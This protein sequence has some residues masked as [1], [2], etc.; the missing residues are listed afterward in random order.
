MK[1]SPKRVNFISIQQS[2]GTFAEGYRPTPLRTGYEQIVAHR[3]D[4]LFAT[5]AKQ[6]G[7][8]EKVT[9]KSITL[10]MADGSRKTVELGRRFGVAAG[11]IMPHEVVSPLK[12]GDKVKSGDIIAYN[13]HYFELDALNNKQA[14]W[15]AG[16]LVKTAI[17]ESTDTLEDS[18]V[19]SERISKELQ[20]KITTIREIVVKS[21]Q[22]VRNLMIE[23]TPVEAESILC[24]IEDAVTANNPLLDDESLDTLR[25]IAANAPRA[26]EKGV[27]EKIEVFYHAELDEL[28]PTLQ[29]IAVAS[30]KQRKRLARELGK[31]YTPGKVDDS[32]RID[33]NPL[34][35]DNVVI[36][37]YITSDVPAGVGDK[38]VFANQMKTIFG[39]VMSGVNETE[40]GVPI[41]ALFSYQSISNRIVLSPEIMGTTNTLL[42]VIGQH[43]ADVYFGK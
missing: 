28:S 27:V 40:S 9:D 38:G 42:S 30:D 19:I 14:L 26:K 32:M 21:D 24:I 36:R 22:S 10:L 39:R 29:E 23:G 12:A 3:T 15:K 1:V 25:L 18:S 8:V 37:V 34:P 31:G 13:S 16:V 35:P 41:D 33:G 6:D 20:T 5:T 17:L 4:D 43:V 2:S 11:T 7:T